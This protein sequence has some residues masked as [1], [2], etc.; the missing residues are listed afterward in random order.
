MEPFPESSLRRRTTNETQRGLADSLNLVVIPMDQA[1]FE[2][3]DIR[4]SKLATAVWIPLRAVHQIE[5]IGKYGFLG[6]R[7]DFYGAGSL[8]VPIKNKDD[9]MQLGW[10]SIGISHN[11]AGYV[12]DGRYI[13]S[14]VY[15]SHKAN[16]AGLHL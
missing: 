16:F 1:W 14:D 7:E 9:A 8:A 10:D 13:P 3:P 6:F 5:R 12:D 2:M 11:H 4:R 15:E